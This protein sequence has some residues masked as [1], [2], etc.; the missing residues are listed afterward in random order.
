VCLVF[1]K[2][3]PFLPGVRQKQ[4][5]WSVLIVLFHAV[6]SEV[7]VGGELD[8]AGLAPLLRTDV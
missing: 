2:T 7:G 5:D 8:G 6:G 1:G 3:N 4:S